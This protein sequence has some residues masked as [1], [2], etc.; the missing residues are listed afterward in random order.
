MQNFHCECGERVFFDNSRCLRCGL[1]LGFLP[2]RR[3]LASLKPAPDGEHFSTAYGAYR[4]CANYSE[5]GVCN[6]MVPS[7]ESD[8][9]CEACRLNNVIPDLSSEENLRLWAEVEKAKRRLVFGLKQL[10]LPIVSKAVDP[11]RGIAFDLKS[12]PRVLTGHSEGLITLNLAEADDVTRERAKTAMNERYR[13]L[14]GHFRHEIGHYYWER[15]VR[16]GPLEAEFRERFGDEREDY[17]AALKRHYASPPSPDWNQTYISAYA[18]AHPWE[19]W[20]ETFAHYLHIADTLETAQ[21]FGFVARLPE[22]ATAPARAD[23]ELLL[24][25]WVELSVALN[26][27]NRSMGLPDAYPFA[28]AERVKLKLELVHRAIRGA[29]AAP[30]PA[31][32]PSC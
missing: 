28:I 1:E 6:W 29:G 24:A 4:K 12:G 17:S 25:E 20:A 11:E 19:D 26:A 5:Q 10:G 22:G 32:R 9:L 3:S 8:P 7:A 21:Q 18:S 23:L 14:L 15:L 27:L 16:D 2:D 30:G 31:I 13:T